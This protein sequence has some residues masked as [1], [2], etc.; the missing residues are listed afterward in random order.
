MSKWEVD[1]P[2]KQQADNTDNRF[3]KLEAGSTRIRVIDEGPA[4]RWVHWLGSKPYV[5]PEDRTCPACQAFFAARETDPEGAR[6]LGRRRSF[7]I[8][9]LSYD[10]LEVKVYG[11]GN[12]IAKQFAGL[13]TVNGDLRDYDVVIIKT[14]T[15]ADPRNVSYQVIPGGEKKALSAEQ[16]AVA[17]DKIDLAEFLAPSPNNEI[18]AALN[19]KTVVPDVEARRTMPRANLA[20]PQEIKVLQSA[21]KAVGENLQLSDFGVDPSS[22]TKDQVQVL[23]KQLATAAP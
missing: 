20:S 1:E 8:N 14:K 6:E 23:L 4:K 15:G 3:L 10:P 16:Q 18:E 2:R 13:D 11:F 22:V 19:G 7:L 9:V 5:C 17:E 12:Q 21:I